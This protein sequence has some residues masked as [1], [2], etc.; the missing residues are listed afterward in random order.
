MPGW[1][2]ELPQRCAPCRQAGPPPQPRAG[3]IRVRR[4]ASNAGIVAVAGQKV[5]L[6][7]SG[8]PKTVTIDVA[9]DVLHIECD[10]DV[11]AV[12]RTAGLAVRQIKAQRPARSHNSRVH[13]HREVLGL[14]QDG[15]IRHR[16]DHG[17]GARGGQAVHS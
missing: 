14:E 12:R 13:K 4:L 1:L 11:R 3:P 5:A 15:K 7:R 2:P 6:R 10:D 16:M 17:L 9:A 8:A